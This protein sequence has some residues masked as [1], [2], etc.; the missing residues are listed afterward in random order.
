MNFHFLSLPNQ[1]QGIRIAGE[2]TNILH[3]L[4]LEKEDN[5]DYS[6]S[7]A[8]TEGETMSPHLNLSVECELIFQLFSSICLFDLLRV[9]NLISIIVHSTIYHHFLLEVSPRC[10]PGTE[11]TSVV[12]ASMHSV[13]IKCEVEADPSDLIKFHWTYNNTR[14]VS[15][16]G[17]M[18]NFVQLI[19]IN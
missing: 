5:G 17:L 14:N 4:S 15:P 19:E 13:Q 6:C 2:N 10:K 18:M 12:A 3:I 9:C 1:S 8:N 7:A 16:V 11:Q